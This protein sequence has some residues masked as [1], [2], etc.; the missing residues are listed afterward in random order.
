MFPE[1]GLFDL[2]LLDLVITNTQL[3]NMK[4]Q[5]LLVLFLFIA[6]HWSRPRNP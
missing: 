1:P 3:K 2:S 4:E 6:F 5:V